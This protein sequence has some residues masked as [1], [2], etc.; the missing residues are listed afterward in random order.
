MRSRMRGVLSHSVVMMKFTGRKSG[1]EFV[2]PVGYNKFGN[3]FLIALS[4]TRNR[5]WWLNYRDPWPMEI[6][7]RGK[8]IR[9]KAVVLPP[10]SEEYKVGFEKIFNRHW[11]MPH[12][13]KIHDY[14]QE[15]GLTPVQLSRM[16][17]EGNGLVRFTPEPSTP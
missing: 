6:Q 8:W 9:G 10:D 4:D 11:F 5:K 7:Y 17:G 12:I 1:K 2:T 16:H 14:R 3:T 13:L 15:R